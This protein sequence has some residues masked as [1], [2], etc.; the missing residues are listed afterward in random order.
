MLRFS[1][2]DKNDLSV[3]INCYE[4]ELVEHVNDLP[5]RRTPMRCISAMS[6]GIIPITSTPVT[7]HRAITIQPCWSTTVVFFVTSTSSTTDN[8]VNITASREEGVTSFTTATFGAVTTRTMSIYGAIISCVV[9]TFTAKSLVLWIIF[10][11]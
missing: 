4:I 1:K 9:P 5:S 7:S 6:N 3:C 2:Q 11:K 8:H 10:V